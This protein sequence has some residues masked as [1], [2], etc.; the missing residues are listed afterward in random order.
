MHTLSYKSPF[1]LTAD[2]DRGGLNLRYTALGELL[3]ALAAG[4]ILTNSDGRVLYM[5]HTAGCQAEAGDALCV[6]NR[7]LTP[8]DNAAR[9]SLMEAITRRRHKETDSLSRVESI[10]LPGISTSGLVAT[11]LSMNHT[12]GL[13]IEADAAV[14]V[15]LEAPFERTHLP[16][17]AFAK[18]YGLTGCELRTLISIS[19]SCSVEKAAADMGIKTCTAKTHLQHIYQKTNTAKLSELLL[20][21]AHS[22]LRHELA[23]S[24]SDYSTVDKPFV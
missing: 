19:L 18:L 2:A 6:N 14:A 7:R 1:K 23:R 24:G 9:T 5:N 17:K 16:S 20:L 11:V 4:I 12:D 3:N 22:V 10:A 13:A 8:T 15:F 21:F